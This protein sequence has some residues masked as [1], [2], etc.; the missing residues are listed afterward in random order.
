[1]TSVVHVTFSRILRHKSSISC[2]KLLRDENYLLSSST[3]GQVSHF[4]DLSILITI[5]SQIVMW[6]RRLSK[7]VKQYEG[8]VCNNLAIRKFAVDEQQK[9]LFAGMCIRMFLFTD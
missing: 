1:M 8:C 5:N 2:L 4:K 7:V 3:D 6:D 9:F